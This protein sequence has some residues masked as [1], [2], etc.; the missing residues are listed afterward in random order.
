MGIL[1]AAGV[2]FFAF[3]G[4]DAVST[5]AQEAKNPKRDMPIGILGSLVVCTILYVLF[6]HVLSG[7]ATV[8]DFRTAGKEASVTFAITKYMT[9][10]GWLAKFVTVAILAGFSSVILVMLMGQSRVFF[11]MSR[12][13]LVPKVFSEVHPKYQ[14]PYKSNMLFFLFTSLFAAFLPESI[15][16]EM[17]SIG[18]LFAFMLVCAGVWI[19]R[20][21]RPDIVRGFTVPALPVVSVLGILV[22]GAMIFGLGWTNWVR[23]L[24]WLV[25][26]LCIYFGY[27]ASHSHLRMR[28]RR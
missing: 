4:F 24:V 7:V 5:A 9:G 6:S 19:M 21:R 12:D 23:L 10:Y 28:S 25:I 27:S 18:T 26:G 20:R 16:G 3:I 1:G 8:N 2:V 13:G 11:S 22:C 15:V 17:T 14:T